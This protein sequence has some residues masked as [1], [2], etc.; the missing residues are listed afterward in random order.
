MLNN[1]HLYSRG[2]CLITIIQN[3]QKNFK[4]ETKNLFFLRN[5]MFD[6]NDENLDFIEVINNFDKY[7]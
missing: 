7:I 4:N 1:I 5:N 6:L 3:H 2:L